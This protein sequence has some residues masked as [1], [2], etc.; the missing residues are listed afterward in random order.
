M[1]NPL[2]T[3]DPQNCRWCKKKV[4]N[5]V[6]CPVCS[7]NYHPCCAEKTKKLSSGGFSKCCGPVSSPAVSP[8]P[9]P[10]A[11]GTQT[12]VF[13][14]P[15]DTSNPFQIISQQISNLS[16]DTKNG[17]HRLET[18][19]SELKVGFDEFK[20]RLDNVEGK[21]DTVQNEMIL[22]QG[23]VETL[24]SLIN[25]NV[26]STDSILKEFEDMQRRKSNLLIFGQPEVLN[27]GGN[28]NSDLDKAGVQDLINSIFT[29]P[30]TFVDSLKISRIGKFSQARP[31]PRP[32][33]IICE[34]QVQ[35]SSILSAARSL[36]L[37]NSPILQRLSFVPDRT[38][39][40]QQA[41]RD[42]KLIMDERIKNGETDLVIRYIK[43]IP[44]ITKKRPP[45]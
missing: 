17:M 21:V 39:R 15:A 42:Q 26:D 23:R 32:V 1:L 18:S 41:F 33:K 27:D 11:S 29:T 35:A 9:T 28:Y 25:T 3:N 19:L 45:T 22:V 40:Q 2:E 44:T 8:L 24:E 4:V 7:A 34:T 20:T 16:T 43:G 36:R 31:D 30:I 14:F 38:M 6:S 10:E 37:T 12:S 13:C 5:P